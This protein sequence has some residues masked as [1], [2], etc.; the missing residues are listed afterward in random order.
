MSSPTGD[1]APASDNIGD[2]ALRRAPEPTSDIAATAFQGN[3]MDLW[4]NMKSSDTASSILGD[5]FQIT[6]LDG[7]DQSNDT[8]ADSARET[9]QAASSQNDGRSDRDRVREGRPM[10]NGR[11]EQRPSGPRGDGLFSPIMNQLLCNQQPDR[12]GCNQV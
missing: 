11:P 2:K 7:D 5:D 9:A 8:T 6:G 1:S 4:R 10:G 12:P 3:G